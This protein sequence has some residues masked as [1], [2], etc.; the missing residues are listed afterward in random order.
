MLADLRIDAIRQ[1][2]AD[3]DNDRVDPARVDRHAAVSA[4]LRGDGEDTQVL[5][6]RRSER[7][8]DP[9]SGHMAFPGGHAEPG[10]SLIDA[11]RRET[12]EELSL[13]LWRHARP[14][15]ELDH[16][17]AVA[18]GR[19]LDMVIAPFVF[20]LVDDPPELVPD[21]HEVAGYVWAPLGPMITGAAHTI[22]EHHM[23]GELR[24][25]PGYDVE[26]NVVW[27]LT[28]RILGTLFA[29][30]HPDWEPNEL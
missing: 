27:G 2:L 10:E 7:P 5:L 6:I 13:D 8:G 24:R 17:H 1:V 25:F 3:Y 15:G 11:A 4:V 18:R 28:Y 14:I 21:A 26:G 30:L 29:L 20:E 22:L 12:W 19:R 9:W 16:A 23:E